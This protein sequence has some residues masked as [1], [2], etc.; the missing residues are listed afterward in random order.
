MALGKNRF[1]MRGMALQ[2]LIALGVLLVH[3]LVYHLLLMYNNFQR[4]HHLRKLQLLFQCQ[5]FHLIR[6]YL[7]Q[8]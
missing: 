3:L 5:Y 6:E 8:V 7:Y 2:S 4:Y 1:Y